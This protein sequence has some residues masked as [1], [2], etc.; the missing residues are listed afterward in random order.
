MSSCSRITELRGCRDGAVVRALAS[1]QCGQGSIPRS[2]IIYGLSLLV[3]YSA[4]RGFLRVL[5]FPLSSKTNIWLDLRWLLVSVYSVPNQCF[6][7]RTTWHLNKVPFLSFPS[8]FTPQSKRL[9]RRTD[10]CM[11]M[12]EAILVTCETLCVQSTVV[13]VV[14]EGDLES[15]WQT[16]KDLFFAAVRDYIPTKRLWGGILCPGSQAP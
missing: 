12:Q 5:R 1:H 8:S 15:C 9:P 13:I 2:G 7:A 6:S 14:N 10:P 4:P 16:W 11:I 3:L